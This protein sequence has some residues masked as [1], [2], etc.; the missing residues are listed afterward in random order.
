[1]GP[2]DLLHSGDE[3]TQLTAN[4]ASLLICQEIDGVIV[5]FWAGGVGLEQM[6]KAACEVAFEAADGFAAAFALGEVSFDVGLC[7]GVVLTAL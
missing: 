3:T 1:M 2:S 4:T 6:P 7:R 5:S